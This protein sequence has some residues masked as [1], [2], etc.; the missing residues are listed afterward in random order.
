MATYTA[1]DSEGET[2]FTWSLT[3]D[4]DG[5]FSLS[6][7]VLT[8][9]ASPDYEDA[10][11]A[12]TDNDYH[13][14]INAA[15][16]NGDSSSLDV[17]VTVTD[18]DEAGLVSL[19]SLQPQSGTELTATLDDEDAGV[20]NTTWQWARSADGSTSWSNISSA[21]AASYIPVD[22]DLDHY[23]RATVSY[24]DTHGS[25]KSVAAVSAN[26]VQA[27]PVVST[28]P[29]FDDGDSATRTVAENSAEGANVGAAVA[30]TDS[31]A[32]DVLTFALSGSGSSN[33][34]IDAGGQ[35][36]VASGATLDHETTP[37]YSLS[38]TVHDGKDAD[39]NAD[40][41]VDDTITVTINVTDVNEPP[42]LSGSTGVDYA[43][44]G[45]TS[46]ATYTAT[47][48]EGET[49]FTWSLT[50]DDGGLFSISAGVLTFVA[51]PDYEDAADA[52][53][54]NDYQVT[55]N[56]ADSYSNSSS[57]DVTVNVTNVDEDGTVSFDSLQPQV[58]TA[59]TASL[60]DPD[61]T[62]SGE[63]WQWSSSAD[64][65]DGS[66]TDI[67]GATAA[68]YTPVDAD[69]N[70]YLR[71]T[72]SYTD[73]HGGSKSAH[74]DTA[75]AVRAP[76]NAPNFESGE[77]VTLS[78]DENTGTE[79]NV[80]RAVTATDADNDT[81]TYSL[82]GTDA[83]SFA[84]GGDSGQITVG[85]GTTLDYETKDSYT[86]TVEVHDGV[87]ADGNADTTTD[88]TITVTIN[89]TNVDEVP[90]LTGLSSASY[91]E[92]GTGAVGTYTAVDPES[93]TLSWTLSSDDA[94]DFSISQSGELTFGSAPN[95]ESAQDADTDNE[96]LVTVEVSD[97]TTGQVTLDVTIS[98]T[99]ADEA[100]TVSLDSTQPQVGTAVTASLTDPD[101]TISSESWQWSR[102]ADGSTNWSD[103]SGAT[104][105]SYTP[106]SADLNNYL[107]ATVSYTDG[108]GAGKSAQADTANTVQAAPVTNSAPAFNS[109]SVTLSVEE[110]TGSGENVGSAVTATDADNDTLTYSLSGTDAASFGF[111]TS[112]GQIT[113]SAAL[114]YETTN[115]YSVTVEVHDGKNGQGDA[116]TSVDDTITVTI[117]VTNVDEAPDLSGQ[118]SIDYAENGTTSVATYTATD[119]EGETSFTW[120]LT[121]DDAGL[122][123]ISAGVLTFV[124]SPDYEDARDANT[125]ND[126][127]V[128][129]H[130]ADSNGNSSSLDVTVN[131]TDMDEA[132][133]VSL[134]SL[135]PQVGTELTA[136]LT[137]ADAGVTN[138]T[139]QWARSSDGSTNWSDISGA[140]AASY[141]PVDADLDHYL[142][143]TATYDD[144]HGSGKS[145]A[146]VSANPVQ[147]APVVNNQP[148]FDDGDNTTRTVAE[149]S[150]QDTGVG[151][152]VAATDADVGD[153]LTYALSGTGASNFEIDGSGQITVASGATLDHETTP[154][155]SLSATVHDGKDA[156]GNADTSVDDTITVTITVTDVHEA[157]GKPVS[158]TVA[159][160][161]TDGLSVSWNAPSNTGPA[162][163]D[164]DVRYSVSGQAS[165]TETDDT[166]D[167]TET[168][169]TISGLQA[170]MS[171][172]VQ[173]RGGTTRGLGS[174]RSL[175]LGARMR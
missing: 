100:G 96:Y 121:G 5:L 148:T 84:I 122:F 32:G 118:T 63:S 31:N 81:L 18:V 119:P 38:A 16:S 78:V 21:T 143:A 160:F 165:W 126:Y 90:V 157:P 62:V 17:T 125:D 35:I 173:V 175:E 68:N 155:Y 82:S 50:G 103:I 161:G 12:N 151:N 169:A 19:N 20:T 41:S 25:G 170:G 171:Y 58:G 163:T 133:S 92:N 66:W 48:P 117:N 10:Q 153:T 99:N 43:E 152:M 106:V 95:Y 22:A 73:G 55:I 87:D 168:N 130:A 1:T 116:D 135:Q 138:T 129:I 3:G 159:A 154:S 52:N 7:G 44:N 150:P 36:T 94:G 33:F 24:A 115:S 102:S 70:H 131:V 145:I 111:D 93:A 112:S 86:V 98:V 28:Q 65:S 127:Q 79:E 172:D 146:A 164:Y 77:S 9:D 108:H 89:V 39:G 113:T 11:D 174:G 14:T 30:A 23:L 88:D 167:N 120:S 162:I 8:F 140:T 128:T 83:G 72:A 124:A 156:D 76:N 74:A 6:A 149:N 101:G 142:R 139:W 40:T 114:D 27:A 141:T 42:E 47:D 134:E 64:G 61:R 136:S 45:T 71:A 49:S 109:E 56:A 147:A 29:T 105:A 75:N 59:I 69:L 46:V 54:D 132:G 34:A 104:S 15:D 13:V 2:S 85:T 37:S 144:T 158:P 57:L 97:G 91:A 166:T 110:N 53:T 80:G 26:P 107:R 123:S 137:D 51:P 67:S 60:T 4:D